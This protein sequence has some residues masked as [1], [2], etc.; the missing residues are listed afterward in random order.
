[1]RGLYKSRDIIEETFKT[2]KQACG[3]E[4]MQQ[5]T[6]SSYRRHLR[7][8][9]MA[10][11]FLDQQKSPRCTTPNKLRRQLISGRLKVSQLELQ[12]CHLCRSY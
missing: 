7:L 5:R 10:F 11:L 12:L 3:W 8:G 1:M 9:L 6:V 4:G 2:L